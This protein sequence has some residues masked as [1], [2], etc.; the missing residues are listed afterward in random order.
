MIP[1]LV[2]EMPT[3]D[4]L[5]PYLREIDAARWYSN[6]GPL[7]RRLQARL[8]ADVV[9]N[10]CAVVSNGT[11]ALELALRAM[12]LPAGAG[13]LVPAVTF[14]ATGQAVV[15]AGLRPVLCDVDNA[16]WQLTPAIARGAAAAGCS[17]AAVV[18][19]A[20]FGLPCS[21]PAWSG[22]AN[23][24]GHRV[25]IDA[26]GAIYEQAPSRHPDVAIAYSM[27][28]TKA[29]GAGEGGVVAS[30]DHA[31]LSRVESLAAFGPGGGNAKLS[32]YHA[33]VA[34]ASMARPAGEWRAKLASSYAANLPP[35]VA[36]Q[37]GPPQQRRTLL[38]V[39]LP[40]P[41]QAH[42]AAHT[43]QSAGVGTRLWYRPFLDDR[44]QFAT[45]Q[46]P[47]PLPVTGD[48]KM[49]LIG[50]PYHHLLTHDDVVEV[51]DALHHAIATAA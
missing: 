11:S 31:F 49:G 39:L 41:V 28:A 10:P 38:P 50:L 40:K 42:L 30:I 33:A 29:L 9:R 14:V 26:A 15:A 25:L 21:V 45:C 6:G 5:A 51:C 3:A 13:V 24:T 32:E 46:R 48:L 16:T 43:L 8:S 47:G 20:T 1:V 34:L 44:E 18:P 17:F 4:E 19:V 23:A 2:P 36:L 37:A 27:H 12:Q 22:Y 35:E 7:V